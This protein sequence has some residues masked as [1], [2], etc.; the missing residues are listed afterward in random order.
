MINSTARNMSTR[1]CDDAA[2]SVTRGG[3][4][5][6]RQQVIFAGL[7]LLYTSLVPSKYGRV[8]KVEYNRCSPKNRV[9]CQDVYEPAVSLH[10][11]LEICS[12][13]EVVVNES[14][15]VIH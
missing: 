11:L 3:S 12:D 6:G 14:V 1:P 4:V 13:P 15:D 9:L 8:Y 2:F 10:L 5:F 7:E